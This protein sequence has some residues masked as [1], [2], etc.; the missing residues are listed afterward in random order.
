MNPISRMGGADGMTL[1]RAAFGSM[2]KFCDKLEVF[3]K[4]TEDVD[5][6]SKD[7]GDD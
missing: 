2:L 1:T 5:F 4:L 3:L 6:T 7:I